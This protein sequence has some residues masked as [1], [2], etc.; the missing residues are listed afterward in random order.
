MQPQPD[1]VHMA[2]LLT[3]METL[4]LAQFAL[5]HVI[6]WLDRGDTDWRTWCA[7]HVAVAGL[8]PPLVSPHRSLMALLCLER[9]TAEDD[10][11]HV[12]PWTQHQPPYAGWKWNDDDVS[13]SEACAVLCIRDDVTPHLPCTL[14]DRV[15][16]GRYHRVPHPPDADTDP[17]DVLTFRSPDTEYCLHFES[18]P[19]GQVLG[20]TKGVGDASY[21]LPEN[22]V[23]PRFRFLTCGRCGGV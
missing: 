10:P 20:W 23:L 19:R 11:V 2:S 6:R 9:T 18:S 7:R 22:A 1:I 3:S 21:M 8:A 13:P 4:R 14:M 15:L 17:T 5:I 12:S 16:G